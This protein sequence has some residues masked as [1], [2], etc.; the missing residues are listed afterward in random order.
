MAKRF[1]R[2]NTARSYEV[3][4]INW[5]AVWARACSKVPNSW[6]NWWAEKIANMMPRR[7]IG[8]ALFRACK[9]YGFN[10]HITLRAACGKY[11]KNPDGKRGAK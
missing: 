1:S 6:K 9:D 10:D 4:K 11:T 5:Q 8:W 7:V 2:L 3:I